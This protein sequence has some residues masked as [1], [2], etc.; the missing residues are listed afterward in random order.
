MIFSRCCCSSSPPAST[1]IP[2]IMHCFSWSWM[3]KDVEAH[4][5]K[6]FSHSPSTTFLPWSGGENSAAF[7]CEE[8]QKRKS[9]SNPSRVVEKQVFWPSA[10]LSSSLPYSSLCH[11]Q[12]RKCQKCFFCDLWQDFSGAFLDCWDGYSWLLTRL[13]LQL[14]KPPKLL[15]TLFCEGLLLLLFCLINWNGKIHF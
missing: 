11:L 15:G 12:R 7:T 14:T 4:I 6:V 10:Y 2:Q 9:T 1:N 3:R 8:E 13:L 5:R